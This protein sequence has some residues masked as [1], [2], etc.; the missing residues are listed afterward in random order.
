MLA[1]NDTMEY[2][3]LPNK[4]Y[5]LAKNICLYSSYHETRLFLQFI[6]YHGSSL[7]S[8]FLAGTSKGMSSRFAK[9]EYGSTDS[10]ALAT[11]SQFDIGTGMSTPHSQ[12]RAFS[13]GFFSLRSQTMVPQALWLMFALPTYAKALSFDRARM[14]LLWL[15][16]PARQDL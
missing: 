2:V 7:G 10:P 12:F 11:T 15:K 13:F 14:I 9:T 8:Y 4:T 1:L 6:K 3:K 16:M 5:P